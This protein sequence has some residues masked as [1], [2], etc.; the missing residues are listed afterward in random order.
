MN[1]EIGR[2]PLYGLSQ[3]VYMFPQHLAYSET[4]CRLSG[5]IRCPCRYMIKTMA[6]EVLP[7]QQNDGFYRVKKLVLSFKVDSHDI[8]SSLNG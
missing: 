6:F 2:K 8:F 4:P 3:V 7:I 5:S 1:S